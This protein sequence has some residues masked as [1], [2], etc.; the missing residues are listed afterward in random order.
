MKSIGSLVRT[1]QGHP[2]T[3]L[4]D[5]T[6]LSAMMP[7]SLLLALEY[8]IVE[9]WDEL[10]SSQR[11]LRLEEMFVLTGLL[12][13]GVFVFV[14]RRFREEREDF[15]F[16]VRSEVEART[17]L[18][19]AMQDP[20]TALPN[21]RELDAA[22]AAAISS[23]SSSRKTHAFY[24][25]D[26]NGFKRVNDE[27]GHAMGD[28]VLRAVAQRLQAVA[29]RGD[30]LV[31]LGGDEFAVLA[32]GVDGREQASEIGDRLVAALSNDIFVGDQPFKVGVSI[33]VALYPK[34]GASADELMH[35][36]DLAMYQAK[37]PIDPAC[38]SSR[39]PLSAAWPEA[40]ARSTIVSRETTVRGTGGRS[41]GC[42]RKVPSR[43]PT[44]LTPRPA[45]G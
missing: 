41:S 40:A 26:L 28:E 14:L 4:Q 43:F 22:L 25:L 11:R 13:L 44:P 15:E 42:W 12:G 2:W 34:D 27:H 39:P 33:G 24:L 1:V 6:L 7:V 20:L 36:A 8:D 19:L 3:S 45:F 18:A 9:F 38:A 31:R 37:A 16:K 23:P 30:L 5:A 29:R 35:H 10:S 17:N 32:R 21:R